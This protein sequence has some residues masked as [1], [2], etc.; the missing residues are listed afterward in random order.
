MAEQESIGIDPRRLDALDAALK[1]L[2]VLGSSQGVSDAE[3]ASSLGVDLNTVLPILAIIEQRRMIYRDVLDLY[4]LGPQIAFLGRQ[5]SVR[6]AL[7]QI[8]GEV[9]DSLVKDTRLNAAVIVRE[10]LE[11]VLV[12]R[13]DFDESPESPLWRIIGPRGPLY[14]GGGAKLLLAYAPQATIDE[15]VSSHLADFLPESMRSVDAVLGLLS[16]IRGDGYYLA[17]GEHFDAVFTLTAPIRDAKGTVVAAIGVR[18][19][20]VHLNETYIDQLRRCVLLAAERV[21]GYL[22]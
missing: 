1:I 19:N 10:N 20:T 16:D 22:A 9:L 13:R 5:L 8:S 2:S 6:N 3:I 15:V 4:W 14:K 18:G 11:A 7:N 21:S 17:I 12:A